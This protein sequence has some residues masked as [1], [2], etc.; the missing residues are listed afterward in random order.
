MGR[1]GR[2]RKQGKREPNGRIQRDSYSF[3]KGSEW[4]QSRRARFGEHYSTA[5]GRAYAAGLLGEEAEAKGRYDAGKRF[6]RLYQRFIGGSAYACPLDRSP[7]G[8]NV[9]EL[10][11]SD[12]QEREH[13]WLF[14]AMDSMDVAGCRPYFDQLISIVN[15]DHGP[16]WLDRLLNGSKDPVDLMLLKG[17]LR[18]L[19]VITPELR[20]RI[21]V[22]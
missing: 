21:L 16:L 13:D 3:D 4:V 2:K 20:Q 8:E 18:A 7:R 14:A 6:M 17:A 10:E 9:V 19:D 1:A 11:I 12:Q 5:L 22:A 15:V